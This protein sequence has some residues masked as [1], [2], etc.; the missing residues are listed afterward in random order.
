MFAPARYTAAMIGRFIAIF[1]LLFGLAGGL[2]WIYSLPTE[3]NPERNSWWVKQVN[4][5]LFV[6]G[7][8][9]TLTC[10]AIICAIIYLIKDLWG[11]SHAGPRSVADKNKQM[12]L[13]MQMIATAKQLHEEGK[14]NT[15]R[16]WLQDWLKRVRT[17]EDKSRS[18]L[19]KKFSP[20][21]CYRF[22]NSGR[23]FA[24]DVIAISEEHQNEIARLHARI[25][26]LQGMLG[27][28]RRSPAR[29]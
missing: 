9:F 13:L 28:M 6:S 17:F 14:S 24:E 27:N 15:N 18:V 22:D 11:K 4:S 10:V 19:S 8:L 26:L 25:P 23:S 29:V 20:Y 1:I 3:I 5:H 12:T 21:H 2:L 7:I 16:A